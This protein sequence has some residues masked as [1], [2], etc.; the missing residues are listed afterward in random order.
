MKIKKIIR[1]AISALRWPMIKLKHNKVDLTSEVLSHVNMLCSNVG[2]YSFVQKYCEINH[3]VIGSY[4]S[5]ASNVHIGG[6]EHPIQDISMSV[7]LSDKAVSDNITTIGND[8]WIG[9]QSIIRQGVTIG[10]GA[11]IGCN[12]FVN[13]DV[14]SYAIV[15]GSPAK[16]IRYRF[17][18]V[19]IAELQASKYWNFPPSKARVVLEKIRKHN[20]MN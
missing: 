2:K 15:V 14:P 9:S 8:V 18:E 13:K 12:S 17:N 5:I 7:L 20:N 3:A 10:D 11:V 19:L 16:I 4:C 1:L 6:M